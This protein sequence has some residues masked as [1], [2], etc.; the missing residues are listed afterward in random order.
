MTLIILAFVF[1]IKYILGGVTMS[2]KRI[3]KGVISAVLTVLIGL[4][5]PVQVFASTLSKD[6]EIYSSFDNVQGETETVGNIVTEITDSRTEN[7]KEFLLDD[8]TT[9][10][11]DYNQPV[12]YKN[13]KGKWVE[14]NN[15]LVAES[16]ASTADEA[17][18]GEYTNKNSNIDVKLSNKAKA[19][20]MIKV[21]SDDY[22][23]SWG[24]DG[25]NK[26]K[27]NIVKNDEKLNGN[28]KFTTLKNITTEA[29]YENVYKNVDLQYF[30][31]STGVKENIILKSSDV[32][33]EFNLKYKIKNL[34][35][36]QTDD[37]TITLYNKNN[38][39]VY[40]I[41]APY[42]T[43]AKGESSNQ[44]KLEIA[45]QKGGNLNVKL[46]ADYWFI[47]SIGRSFPIA[48]DPEVTNKLTK[49]LSFSENTNNLIKTYG[50]YYN[51]NNSYLICVANS[52]P[53]LEDGEKIVSAKYN[54]EITNGSSQL[55]N[56]NDNPIIINAHKLTSAANG[57]SEY[58]SDIL[59]YDSLTYSDNQYISFDLTKTVNEW[60]DNGDS[61][62]AF[63]LESFDTIGSRSIT[64]KEATKTST[65][66]SLTF[67]Y[68]D[69]TGTESNLS[70]HT[71]PVGYNAQA[72]VSD[73]LGNLVIN[74]SLYEGTGSRMP[75]TLTATY[76]SINYNTAFANGSPSGYGW[77]FS[78][79]Q[80]VRDA[81]AELV[82]KGYNYIY[83]DSDGTDHYLK[84]SDDS[85]EWYDED[86]LGI[87]LTKTDAHILID[88]G[89]TTQT[90]ELTTAGGKL[91]SEKDEHNNAITYTYTDGN[92]TKITDGSGRNFS[93][94]YN[95][96]TNGEKRVS[97]ITCPDGKNI[98]FSYTSSE[99]DKINYLYLADG[100][101]SRFYYN[102]SDLLTTVEHGYFESGSYK[103]QNSVEFT[104]SNG[105]VTQITEYGSDNTAGNRLNITYGNDNT[106]EFSDKL[107]R[108]VTYTFDNS[109]N[110]ISV[111]NA[112][113]Y[114]ESSDSSG[115]SI[116]SGADSFT[117][118][119]ITES[120]E[121]SAVGSGKY[122]YKTNGGRGG[123]TSSG[124]TVTIDKSAPTQ[125]NGQ[126]QYFGTTSIK[127]NNP[128]NSTNS[129]FF[130]GATHQINSTEF[131]GKDITFSAY[132]KTKDVARIYSEGA[133]GATLKIKC[134]DSSG[135]TLND[136]NS[137]GI[138]G[139][140]DWQRLSISVKVPDNTSRIRLFC[141]LRYTS[142][143]AWFDCLQLEEG[144]CANDFNA[145]QNGDFENNNYWLTNENNAISA[146]NGTVTINGE[147]SAYEDIEETT[148]PVDDS[149]KSQIQLPTTSYIANCKVPDSYLF[150]YDEYGNVLSEYHGTV[151]KTI[152]KFYLA[153]S[154][155]TETT[156]PTTGSSSNLPS[157]NTATNNVLNNNY[158]YQNVKVGRAGVVFNLS[159]EA[160]AKS[161]PLSNENRTFGVA[162]NI[163]YKNASVPETHYQDFN[164]STSSKQSIC[165][166][167]SPNDLE[168]EIDYVAFAFVYGY[169]ENEMTIYNAM[170]NISTIPFESSD[171]TTTDTENNSNS[172]SGIE[173][174]GY[175]YCEALQEIKNTNY[176][177][178][179]NTKTYDD[180][181]N[182]VTSESNG[183]GYTVNYTYDINGNITSTKDAMSHTTSFTYDSSNN[184]TQVK[185]GNVMNQYYYNGLGLIS[186]IDHNNFSY[187][188]NYDALGRFISTKIGDVALVSNTYNT[189]SGLLK[190]TIYANGDYLEY[191]Y[192]SYDRIVRIKG[193]SGVLSMFV[194][195]KKGLVSKVI[196]SQNNRTI[197]YYYDLNGN[198]EKKYCQTEEGD[199]VYYVTTN[200]DGEIIEKTSIYGYDRTIVRGTLNGESYVESNGI[201]VS[202]K[203]DDFDRKTQV[204]TSRTGYSNVFYTDYEYASGSKANS[205]TELVSKITQRRGD[206]KLSSF[207]YTYDKNGN[208]TQIKCDGKIIASYTY[209]RYNQ[210]STSYDRST[211]KYT[212]YYYDNAGNIT[213]TKEHDVVNGVTSGTYVEKTYV[214]GDSNWK[215]KL[216]SYNGT[217]ITYDEL[218]NPL[219]YRDGISFTWENGRILKTVK[220]DDN[221]VNMKYDSNGMRIQ[222]DDNNRTVNYHYDGKGNLTGLTYGEN[223]IYFYYNSDG[224]VTSMSFDNSMYYY[225]K[226][227][228]GDV[229]KIVSQSGTTVVTYT[230]D[231]LGKIINMMDTTTYNIGSINP[232]RY[233]GYV[234]DSETGL[235]YLKSRYYDPETGRFIN[236]DVYCDTMSSIFGTNMFTYCN[237]NPVNQVDPE[238]T[239]AMW[240][241]FPD[242][243]NSFGHT[244][245]LIQDKQNQWWY[246]YWGP[247]HA[248]LRPC[249]KDN[250]SMAELNSYLTGFDPRPRHNYYVYA[251]NVIFNEQDINGGGDFATKL[252]DGM[253]G[254]CIN[255]SGNFD[256][257]FNYA[258]TLLNDLYNNSSANQLTKTIYE[259][260]QKIDMYDVCE[261]YKENINQIVPDHLSV[262]GYHYLDIK[263]NGKCKSYNFLLYN[264]V[265]ASMDILSKGEFYSSSK[266]YK[267]IIDENLKKC[268]PNKVYEKLNSVRSSYSF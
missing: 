90:Y 8:G 232:F 184:I 214:Y 229:V 124:G 15:T 126:V 6:E 143:T 72:S 50:P 186:A 133:I 79:N 40:K 73:Y 125:A 192:D 10:I 84:K 64:F 30:V 63:V 266:R 138:S 88:N 180:T 254:G 9:M 222:K 32:Q 255:F 206:F 55:T 103:K 128:K 42:M 36:K 244:S 127:V 201:T 259:N 243:A 210:M 134:Y 223:S 247:K 105:K 66:P 57:V 16:S 168:K 257:S 230:Y 264:C 130:T 7:T 140:Q 98:V 83:T 59:D 111:L 205:T 193:E 108:K 246:F 71:I 20:N 148:V 163:Y 135:A 2:G 24:Y 152:K 195:N 153:D 233:R 99:Y 94:T 268:R 250:F 142:G 52:L 211:L 188:F 93:I 198:V 86:G 113:G 175:I 58:D 239:D 75:V 39:E 218:G 225:I 122:Y 157:D 209:D 41:I 164:A 53:Q 109:G 14:Y 267:D 34:T 249:G 18:T 1:G 46:T 251:T 12:H 179:E 119:Y 187:S 136:V 78:F 158:I 236:A 116:S 67:I 203:T 227:L 169:N 155:S 161:V 121:Q 139:T 47:H 231:S 96:K 62:D 92:V 245:C 144:N 207:E 248:I 212:Y 21:T 173:Y 154:E 23:I 200:S 117:K 262:A 183:A 106:T 110:R 54:F 238:G 176:D 118:N 19:N 4:M 27:I 61:I 45:S 261:K 226:N 35:A 89:S 97:K 100:K 29:K 171:E 177:Y 162:L 25:A 197:Y 80:Y 185:N 215:D 37:Y 49:A 189:M 101:V 178:M 260:G 115:L 48:I 253:I 123:T 28:D 167:V 237:N 33:N 196:D 165:M 68:K 166:A 219:S 112:N 235:Y 104:Y 182:Y 252:N 81:S 132:V 194:Y 172:D 38:K 147:A 241:Q 146:Q 87:T 60:Y 228:Q 3:L 43:D 102:S 224:E 56:E 202:K 156:T 265:Q 216:T 74:Q 141:N 208:I 31:T 204:K 114:L 160:Q 76:N 107:G 137:I 145:L 44:L 242:G 91:L 65:T 5:L 150:T 149:D 11:A 129:A 263:A 17:S 174:D 221:E 70:Y 13:D 159:G 51:S 258:I 82:K 85:E 213:R 191:M 69:F 220:T 217:T 151:D 77:Q 131:N 256:N 22:S 120:T 240:V 190:K 234:Y 199:S 170:M 95:T 26:S 181:G